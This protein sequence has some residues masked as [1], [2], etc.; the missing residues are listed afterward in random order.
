MNWNDSHE[1]DALEVVLAEALS[2]KIRD[3]PASCPCCES[4]AVHVFFYGR[5]VEGLGGSWVWCS[6]CRCSSH[7]LVRIPG[8]WVNVEGVELADLTS[9][10]EFLDG[11]AAR[12]DEHWGA[13]RRK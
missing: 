4:L 6:A 5:G 9:M 1:C 8:W 3:L 12:I 2:G 11:V 10:P 7:G 13:I